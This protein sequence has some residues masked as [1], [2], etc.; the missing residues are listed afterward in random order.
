MQFAQALLTKKQSGLIPVIPDIKCISPKEGDLLRGRDPLAAVKL[1][2][3][4]GAP[5]LSVVTEQ[6]YFG[7]SIKLLEKIAKATTLPLL[8][9]DFIDSTDDLRITKDCGAA[10]ILLICAKLPPAKLRELYEQALQMDLEPLVE[11]HTKEEMD[12][13][14]SI[15]AT[16]I[17]INNRDITD[18]EKDHGTV[19]NTRL[20]ADAKPANALLISESA[21]QAPADARAAI[22]AGADAVLLGTA[23][24]KAEDIRKCF[25]AFSNMGG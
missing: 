11:T 7:G 18:L 16:L 20:L 22:N 19:N 12:F 1:L 21:I 24:W 17:G 6:K 10:A 13:V 23:I 4:A 9:K 15:G 2:K 8:R 3:E 25:L 14:A 5:A